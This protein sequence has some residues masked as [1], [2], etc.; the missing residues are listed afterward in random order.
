MSFISKVAGTELVP[1]SVSML[2]VKPV[3]PSDAFVLLAEAAS[4]ITT[5]PP[6]TFVL[7]S[8]WSPTAD[9][10]AI[11]TASALSLV[12]ISVTSMV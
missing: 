2:I 7:K 11:A 10:T 9:A 4:V 1:P 8:A 3:F 6:S 5:S 12:S